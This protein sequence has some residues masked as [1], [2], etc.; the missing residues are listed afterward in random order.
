VSGSS[1]DDLTNSH[2]VTLILRL[3]LDTEGHLLRGELADI[4]GM[5]IG[6][7]ADRQGL[8]EA[9]RPFLEDG[10][11]EEPERGR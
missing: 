4:E 10:P 3:L 9:L 8:K 2:Y 5:T 11:P 1:T 6:R 7:F